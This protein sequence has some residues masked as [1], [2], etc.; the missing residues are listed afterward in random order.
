VQEIRHERRFLELQ[1]QIWA[2]LKDEVQ[3]AYAQTTDA[4]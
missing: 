4:A 1:N 3:R 2:S